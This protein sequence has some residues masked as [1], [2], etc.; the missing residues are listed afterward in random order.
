MLA[1]IPFIL[2]DLAETVDHTVVRVVADAL[3]AL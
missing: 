2:D 3:A 1:R